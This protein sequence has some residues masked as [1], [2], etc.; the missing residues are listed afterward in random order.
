MNL[1]AWH[2]TTGWAAIAASL[3][4]LA[5]AWGMI[6][7]K[8]SE[9]EISLVSLLM[10]GGS[11]LISAWALLQV[12]EGD[13]FRTN[14]VWIDV[15][16]ENSGLLL[17]WGIRLDFLS[18][19]MLSMVSGIALLVHVFSTEYL[20]KDSAFTRYFT[21]LGFFCSAMMWLILSDNLMMM[22]VCWELVGLASWLLI[23][24]WR[25][26]PGPG[27]AAQK[28]FIVNRIA[29][30]GFL[31]GIMILLAGT[32][33]LD[34]VDLPNHIT[35]LSPGWQ[36]AAALCL[37]IG[38]AGKS[39]Q[40]PFQGWL[41]DAMEGPTPVSSLIHAATMVAA[42]VYLL[43]R[44]AFLIPPEAGMV[45]A[46]IG[47]ITALMAAISAMTQW[48]IKR[49]LAY[50]TI[51]QLGYM[52]MGIGVGARD[53]ALL[54]LFT[55]AFFKCALFLS[56]G[57][58]I[59]A[60]HSQDM[61]EM[62]SLRK[63]LPKIFFAYL[64]PML[65][66]AGLPLFS[67]FLSKDGILLGAMNWANQSGGASWLVPVMGFAAAGL[68]AYYMGRHAWL[69]F[70]RPSEGKSH[71]AIHQP[72]PRMWIP[73]AMLA[74]MSFSLPFALNPLEGAHSWLVAGIGRVEG[75]GK[76]HLA[77][78]GFS[79]L[80]VLGGLGLAWWRRGQ[81]LEPDGTSESLLHKLSFQ[82]FYWDVLYERIIA[83]SVFK[84]GQFAQF[85]DK[86]IIDGG[87]DAFAWLA[88]HKGPSPS[89]STL[90]WKIDDTL[91]D[92]FV[93]GIANGVIRLG[94]VVRRTNTGGVQ[95]TLWLAL[96]IMLLI[97]GGIWVLA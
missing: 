1:H 45:I 50:S 97:V 64:P 20:Q 23:G 10:I 95:Q 88:V 4:L 69:V 25:E 5:W 70:I 35:E 91:I 61:R 93:N 53:M 44:I 85:I 75:M 3:P 56:A 89:L 84:I 90:A 76:F 42:G 81:M 66:L 67:G 26:R 7:G 29:D 59:H 37:F 65:A 52:V 12:W 30:A 34:L 47:A 8:T 6:R 43:G 13:M 22:F 21:H 51:S 87:I 79:L 32:G 68:T 86:K 78:I 39:A 83:I 62:G 46:F 27:H 17:T 82:H 18:A 24:F 92:G 36:T 94:R 14:G 60:I 55:H 33:T 9:K 16:S 96:L 41:P 72:G 19:A 80:M 49:V 71:S 28:A 31:I 38:A 48:D 57:A 73:L 2:I 40:F 15:G 74:V 63:K 77:T 58:V 54:H 11:F